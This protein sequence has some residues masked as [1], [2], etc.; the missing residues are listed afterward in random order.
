MPS[1]RLRKAAETGGRA[2]WLNESR[3]TAAA[4]SVELEHAGLPRRGANKPP[5]IA[6]L[7]LLDRLITFGKFLR[8][9]QLPVEVNHA[10]VRAL[11]HP[12]LATI[13][14]VHFVLGNS[15]H[16]VRCVVTRRALD[17]LA[18]RDLSLAELED[19]FYAYRGEIEQ[20][21]N[22][23]YDGS[24]NFFSALTISPDDLEFENRRPAW[25]VAHSPRQT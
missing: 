7:Y 18:G 6:T 17:V 5:Q 11:G 24:R 1:A 19:A 4:Q 12:P 13:H 20:T 3:P 15:H 9:A 21:A 2:R 25:Q 16:L 23:K 8:L 10:L 22:A 14:G